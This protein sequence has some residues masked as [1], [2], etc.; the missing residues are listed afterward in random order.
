MGA[1]FIVVLGYLQ[2]VAYPPETVAVIWI[3]GLAQLLWQ[4]AS[5][6]QAALQG[7]ET[8]QHIALATVLGKLVN[9]ALGIG[10]LLLGF[11]VYAI[12]GVGVLAALTTVVVMAA[13]LARRY[14]P[15]LGLDRRLAATMLR[16]GLPYLFSGFALVLYTEV[17]ILNISWLVDQQTVGW[18]GAADRLFGTML[19]LPVVFMAS[20]FPSLA[21]TFK[22]NPAAMPALVQRGLN[23][24]LA[25]AAPVGLGIV[26]IADPLVLLLYGPEF[27]PSGAVLAILGVVLIF[28]YVNIVIGQFLI[29]SDRQHYWGPVILAAAI[30]TVP[31][32]LLLIPWG[33]QR[34]GN[35]A[36]G[37]GLSFVVTELLM[38]ATGLAML[39]RGTVT[40]ATLWS[41][42]RVALAG[43]AMVAASWWLRWTFI[44][45]PIAVAA[46]T[47]LAMAWVLRILSPEDMGMLRGAARKLLGRVRRAPEARAGI[48]G[49]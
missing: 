42:L 11:G 14:R 29:A 48:V 36:I 1:G 32:D 8:M 23:L 16:E 43:A 45:V 19:F 38:A 25:L 30:L 21:R 12:A 17:D 9:T 47:Y 31:L 4:L 6:C 27:A 34:F 18:Y 2:I 44:A 49:D 41:A 37:G 5:A 15:I 35:G 40:W 39:P 26:V 22:Q 24:I 33:E 10:A 46:A 20:V 7:L 3:Y 28:T 13:F